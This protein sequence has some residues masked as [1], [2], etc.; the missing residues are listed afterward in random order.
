MYGG[1]ATSTC[2]LI[3][4]IPERWQIWCLP[5]RQPCYITEMALRGWPLGLRAAVICQIH[6]EKSSISHWSLQ[7]QHGF[8]VLTEILANNEHVCEGKCKNSNYLLLL[9]DTFTSSDELTFMPAVVSGII[10]FEWQAS[11]FWDRA[12]L[13]FAPCLMFFCLTWEQGP[14]YTSKLLTQGKP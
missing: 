5:L 8:Q 6:T 1:G 11:H 4:R 9:D 14:F 2:S 3:L 13:L 7:I 12:L 10:I